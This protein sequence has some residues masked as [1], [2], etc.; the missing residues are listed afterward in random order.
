MGLRN[1]ATADLTVAQIAAH[2]QT[3]P[4]NVT[5]SLKRYE[6]GEP[7]R[8]PGFRVF[9]DGP[10]RGGPWRVHRVSYLA[11][12]SIPEEDQK[13]H[14]GPDGLPELI[15]LPAAAVLLGISS[16]TLA[17]K[18]RRQRWPHI[19]FGRKSYLTH[20]QLARIRVAAISECWAGP[21]AGQPTS[22]YRA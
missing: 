5:Y 12:L 9:D 20:N 10:G 21:A 3:K 7:N 17:A 6:R 16:Q 13:T 19:V 1:S 22:D 4:Y 11:F 2:L 14:L 8:L 18:V 15:L